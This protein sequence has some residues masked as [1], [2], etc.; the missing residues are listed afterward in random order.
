MFYL[1]YKMWCSFENGTMESFGRDARSAVILTEE[2]DK[3]NDGVVM[4]AVVEKYVRY[5]RNGIN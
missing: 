4:E 1:P 5:F 2:D 3:H